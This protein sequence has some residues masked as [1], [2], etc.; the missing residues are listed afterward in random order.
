MMQSLWYSTTTT[1]LFRLVASASRIC[2]LTSRD[3]VAYASWRRRHT[4]YIRVTVVNCLRAIACAHGS[5]RSQ[6]L[7]PHPS[8]L[9]AS[10]NDDVSIRPT[11]ASPPTTTMTKYYKNPNRTQ[12]CPHHPTRVTCIRLPYM[13]YHHNWNN[14]PHYYKRYNMFC[15]GPSRLVWFAFGSVATWA[16]YRHHENH[17]RGAAW[18]TC[19]PPRVGYNNNNNNNNSDPGPGRVHGQWEQRSADQS[20]SPPT[21]NPN[22]NNYNNNASSPSPGVGRDYSQSQSESMMTDRDHERLRQIGRSAEETVSTR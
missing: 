10:E 13:P 16:W 14:Y 21:N 9:P 1:I 12:R 22:Y 7:P 19:S 8:R 2:Y 20:Q 17:H 5:S 4:L 18:S 11:L 15:G 6:T 3:I